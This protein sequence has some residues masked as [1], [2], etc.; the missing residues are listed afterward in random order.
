MIDL[1]R[2]PA[3]QEIRRQLDRAAENMLPVLLYGETGTGKDVWAAYLHERKKTGSFVNLHCADIPESLLESQWFGYQK[4]AFTGANRDHPGLWQKARH[5]TLYLNRIDLLRTETQSKLLRVIERKRYYPLGSNEELSIDTHFVFSSAED[6]V[7]QVESGRFRAD[8]YYR[9]S[10][11]LVR[12]PPLRERQE[13]IE[14]LIHFFAAKAGVSVSLSP[15]A[16]ATLNAHPWYGNIR[17]L[18]NIVTRSLIDDGDFGERKF[19]NNL[20]HSSFMTAIKP[21]EPTLR[22]ME[23]HYIEHLLQRYKS[24][25]RVAEIL[26]ITRK[27]L[28]NKLKQHGK[29]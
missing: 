20:E 15:K 29:G 28:Y 1:L 14:P 19:L 9:I 10:T 13:D 25:T 2:S 17:E 18:Q 4:G 8:L 3:S 24:K 21:Q 22:E 27:T 11:F 23:I 26:G 12:I 7:D 16:L 6:I 5:G